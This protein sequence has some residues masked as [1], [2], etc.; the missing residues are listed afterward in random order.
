MI[1][2]TGGTGLLGAHL[3]FDLVS[4][5]NAVRALKRKS[6][7]VDTVK[8]VFSYYSNDADLFNRIEWIEGNTLDVLSLEEAVKGVKTVYHCAAIVSFEL[9]ERDQMMK[10]NVEGTAN[11]V[12]ACLHEGVEK[13]CHVSSTA[14]IGKEPNGNL[15]TEDVEWDNKDTSF[16]SK[17]KYL[18]EQEVWRGREEGLNVVIV[19][20]C[21][22][23]GPGEWGRSSTSVF[24]EVWKGLV[25]YTQGGNA[26]VDV[27][28][29]VKCMVQLTQSKVEGQRF[30]VVSE[31]MLF[32]EF[33]S[34]IA[35]VFGKNPPSVKANK[36][37]TNIAWRANHIATVLFGFRAGLTKETAQ[38]SQTISSYSNQKI[39]NEL[40]IEFTP[41]SQSIKDTS[42]LFLQQFSS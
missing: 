11:V 35:G 3:L 23:L 10:T 20:P 27:R 36:M 33:F 37:A 24:S 38:S 1:F 8:K 6:S 18:S 42:T 2:V 9:K 34:Q 40:G 4:N 17:T 41:V 28:D 29:V 13:L 31:N 14:A 22:I 32:K 12:N 26:F 15:I 16:Y 7:K 25:Y 19:N 21:I 30:L 5:G 39:K